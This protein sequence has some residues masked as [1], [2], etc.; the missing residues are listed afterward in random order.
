MS[1]YL[2]TTGAPR[3]WKSHRLQLNVNLVQRFD[4]LPDKP[5]LSR[6]LNELLLSYV[7]DQEIKQLLKQ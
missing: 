1:D 6:L 2:A 3:E 4:A 5:T 7:V